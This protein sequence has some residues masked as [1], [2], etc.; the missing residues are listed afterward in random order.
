MIDDRFQTS[1]PIKPLS[2]LLMELLTSSRDAPFGLA[3]FIFCT[4]GFIC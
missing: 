1:A 4:M 3:V 2:A